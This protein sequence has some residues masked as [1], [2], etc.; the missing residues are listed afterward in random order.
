MN[1]SLDRVRRTTIAAVNMQGITIGDPD[2]RRG[3]LT[4][5]LRDI[6]GLLGDKGARFVS[7]APCFLETRSDLA[8][9]YM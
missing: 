6:L 1:A 7:P 3:V 2:P 5:D 9:L 4:V 8:I